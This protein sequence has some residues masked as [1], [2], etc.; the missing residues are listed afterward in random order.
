VNKKTLVY[1]IAAGI[2]VA[3]IVPLVVFS[4]LRTNNCVTALEENRWEFCEH[5][6]KM[7]M[8]SV[9]SNVTDPPKYYT[10]M[11]VYCGSPENTDCDFIMLTRVAPKEVS[12]LANG[13]IV[14]FQAEAQSQ[15]IKIETVVHNYSP[16]EGEFV[17]D[18][19]QTRVT[20]VPVREQVQDY[21]NAIS[22][23]RRYQVSLPAGDYLIDALAKWDAEETFKTQS[24]HRFRVKIV[25]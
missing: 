2:A 13:T 21:G 16:A 19:N 14:Q 10:N 4:L 9:T 5:A 23:I 1:G 7:T 25:D 6:P 15:P 24:L 11:N 12:I 8:V 20:L 3:I 22:S 17:V 18:I